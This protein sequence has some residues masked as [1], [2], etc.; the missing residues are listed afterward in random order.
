VIAIIN[1]GSGNIQ[2]IG[3]IYGRLNMPF[4]IASNP[5]DLEKADKI[6]LPGVGAF[7]QVI[8]D[9][10][11]SGLRKALDQA[12]LVDRKPILGICVGMQMF[13]ASSEEGEKKGLAWIDG[14][15]RRFDC[16]GD[17]HTTQLPHMGWNTIRPVRNHALFEGTDLRTGYYFLHSYYFQCTHREDELAV[18]D[19]GIQFTSAVNRENIYGVQFHPEKSHQSGIQLLKN[20]ADRM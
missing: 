20:F 9:L 2:A 6:I 4:V 15:V 10:E 13:A 18:T 7:D 8:G 5:D 16:T 17:C 11:R 19:Y 12:V 3:N 14:Q 1:Y